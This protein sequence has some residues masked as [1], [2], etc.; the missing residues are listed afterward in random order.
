MERGWCGCLEFEVKTV[1][2]LKMKRTSYSTFY[3]S[4]VLIVGSLAQPGAS[5]HEGHY[6][7]AIFRSLKVGKSKTEIRISNR[8]ADSCILCGTS[9][10]KGASSV[11]LEPVKRVCRNLDFGYQSSVK[12]RGLSDHD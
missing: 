8:L 4:G 1:Y 3:A 11:T 6:P 5:K 7:K 12:P 10:G 9:V 2:R